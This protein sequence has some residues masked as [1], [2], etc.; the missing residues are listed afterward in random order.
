[1]AVYPDAKIILTVREPESWH[2]SV[3]GTLY[4]VGRRYG[5]LTKIIPWAHQF[6]N[7]M[8]KVIWEGIFH[9]K[10]ED[11]VHAMEV[12]N[13]HIEEVKRIVPEERLLI[14]EARHGW[15]PLCEFL[16]VPVPANK[17]YPHKN[18]GEP[19]RQVLKYGVLAKWVKLADKI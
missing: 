13:N 5:E 8:E 4:Q 14:F 15:E 2:V 6:F 10:L 17:P 19:I 11:K 7:A 9:N 12:F 3:M 18:N 1:M 16:N